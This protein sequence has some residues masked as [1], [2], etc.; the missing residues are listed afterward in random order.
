MS[1][2]NCS[3]NSSRERSLCGDFQAKSEPEPIL[4]K[5]E[6]GS[7]LLFEQVYAPEPGMKQRIWVTP[8]LS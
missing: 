6:S 7:C 8:L 3:R 2:R 1:I 4:R 5:S